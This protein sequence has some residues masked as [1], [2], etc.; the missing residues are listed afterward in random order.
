MSAMN[1]V[2]NNGGESI[3]KKFIKRGREGSQVGCPG[4]LGLGVFNLF[5]P[6]S[7]SFSTI[8]SYAESSILVGCACNLLIRP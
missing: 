4:T 1:A 3:D 8:I 6:G 5:A 2:H 7:S